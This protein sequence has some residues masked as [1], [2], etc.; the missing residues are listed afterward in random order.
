MDQE[1]E[2]RGGVFVADEIASVEEEK[3]TA[4]EPTNRKEEGEELQQRNELERRMEEA[5]AN[6]ERRME[7]VFV[8]Y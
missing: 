7:T 1:G 5:T 4:A 2:D 8:A 3:A 6:L